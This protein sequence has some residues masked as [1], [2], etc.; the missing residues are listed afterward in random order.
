MVVLSADADDVLLTIEPDTV[1]VIGAFVDHNKYKNLTRNAA[2][3][4]GARSAR[5]PLQ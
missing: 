1:Y 4:H 5:L 3:H 2:C